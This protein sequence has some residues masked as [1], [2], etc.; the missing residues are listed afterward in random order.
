[1][2]GQN[3]R[4]EHPLFTLLMKGCQALYV[5]VTRPASL[6]IS[7]HHVLVPPHHTMQCCSRT[8]W[9][10]SVAAN[11]TSWC[12]PS[13]CPMA[14][15]QCCSQ[16]VASLSCFRLACAVSAPSGQGAPKLGPLH[17]HGTSCLHAHAATAADSSSSSGCSS[18]GFD[19]LCMAQCP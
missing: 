18:F 16:Y 6:L 5:G 2:S 7:V 4:G 19:Q 9:S 10:G 13:G 11:W 17:R 3:S 8:G 12:S 1:M 14:A 15:W